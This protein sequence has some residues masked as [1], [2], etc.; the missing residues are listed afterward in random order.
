MPTAEELRQMRTL[1]LSS[2][3]RESLVDIRSVKIDTALPVEERIADFIRQ[4]KNPY[5]FKCGDLVIQSIFPDTEATFADRLKQY[6]A[7]E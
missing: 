3:D 6:G 4:I 5:F 7:N 1:D 2:I